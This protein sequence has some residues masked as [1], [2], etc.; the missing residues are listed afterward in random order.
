MATSKTVESGTRNPRSGG[1]EFLPD[2]HYLKVQRDVAA[3]QYESPLE[4][5]LDE[6]S[7]VNPAEPMYREEITDAKVTGSRQMVMISCSKADYEAAQRRYDAEAERRQQAMNK[8]IGPHGQIQ[9][10]EDS[11]VRSR[12][13]ILS[14]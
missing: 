4:K 1:I 14:D 2:R 11:F 6:P 9:E 10:E 5:F 12:H 13:A 8:K 3:L 7:I